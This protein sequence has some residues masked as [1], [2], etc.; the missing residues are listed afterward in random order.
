MPRQ[1]PGEKVPDPF[2]G[3]DTEDL[4]KE[5]D[6]PK[7]PQQAGG[8]VSDEARAVGGSGGP[9]LMG[10]EYLLWTRKGFYLTG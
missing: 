5:G 10:S 4:V 6:L 2:S 3:E 7:V 8:I 1:Y 9:S